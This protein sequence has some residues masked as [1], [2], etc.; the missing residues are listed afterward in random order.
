MEDHTRA[1]VM[2]EVPSKSSVSEEQKAEAQ[3]SAAVPKKTAAE[4]P[5]D[6]K[7]KPKL[8]P[9][10]L[11][12]R[13]EH[14]V[15]VCC[16]TLLVLLSAVTAFWPS[17]W[18][19]L[20]HLLTA[21]P[22][23]GAV[24]ARWS[25]TVFLGLQW[26]ALGILCFQ[27]RFLISQGWRDLIHGRP[28]MDILVALGSTA[29]FIEGSAVWIKVW[30]ICRRDPGPL[31]HLPATVYFFSGGLL[32]FLS[33]A[34]Q[35]LEQK[36]KLLR[37]Q[38]QMPEMDQLGPESEIFGTEAEKV[39]LGIS[40]HRL[41]V[42]ST[43]LQ[44]IRYLVQHARSEKI[45]LEKLTDRVAL[46]LVPL[47][48]VTAIIASLSW[49]WTGSDWWR[50]SEILTAVL[51]TGASAVILPAVPQVVQAALRKGRQQGIWYRDAGALA[52]APLVTTV[53]FDKTGT[54][55]EGKPRVNE[56][57][58]FQ[59][60]KESGLLLLAAA[61]LQDGTDPVSRAFRERTL[62]QK[63]PLCTE[64]KRVDEVCVT[65]RCYHENIRFGPRYFVQDH[66]RLPQ[67][68]AA[69][70]QQWQDEGSTVF[71]LSV[72]RYLYA[73]FAVA[74]VLR[75]ESS[76]VVKLLQKRGL[77]TVLMTGDD[78][79]A[80]NH[81]GKLAAAEQVM[82]ELL[83]EQKADYVHSLQL[84][85]E[86]VAM[87]GD[88]LNDAPALAQADLGL[89]FGSKVDAMTAYSADV[90][91]PRNDLDSVPACLQLGSETRRLAKQNTG[92]SLFC[93]LLL[94]PGAAGLGYWLGNRPWPDLALLVPAVLG[95][96]GM[97]L[98]TLRLHFFKVQTYKHGDK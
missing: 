10:A 84:V 31:L 49:F 80:A 19:S 54:L 81:I 8:D 15:Q 23:A 83:P 71:Y 37:L 95:Q 6:H 55:T 13:R 12:V 57:R 85:G 52:A 74:D 69:Q 25:L 96:V 60:G 30:E 92:W 93:S 48:L 86:V 24:L 29:A 46:F 41:A 58:T 11:A 56:V 14:R 26:V 73:M 35:R 45:P 90:V 82:S 89:A 43:F 42:D 34:A 91:L 68:A 76:R 94:L 9:E 87:V 7:V 53:I 44:Q 36:T 67:E 88:W 5:P 16:L 28:S 77:R 20:Q 27:Q 17:V 32:L 59:D 72:G 47:T 1:T 3:E 39:A 50:W 78:K 21:K 2:P 64:V 63:L 51:V 40:A 65:A 75:P 79:R 33:A 70:A 38:R 4:N 18:S 66:I 22:G 62:Q 61:L 98:N 97:E